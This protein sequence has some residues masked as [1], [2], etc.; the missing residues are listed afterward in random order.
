MALIRSIPIYPNLIA[1]N[2]R[3]LINS[4]SDSDSL[5]GAFQDSGPLIFV[6]KRSEILA[7]HNFNNQHSISKPFSS[8]YINSENPDPIKS[9][10]KVELDRQPIYNIFN[11]P[12]N[13]SILFKL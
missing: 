9:K 13:Q 2:N 1:E 8:K 10:R 3:R 6:S 5:S 11:T 12:A 4:D 7:I